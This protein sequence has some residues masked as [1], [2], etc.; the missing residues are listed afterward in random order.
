MPVYEIINPSDKCT[1]EAPGDAVA[2]VAVLLLGQGAFGVERCDGDTMRPILPFFRF[3]SN[4]EVA[5]EAW[6]RDELGTPL[7]DNISAHKSLLAAALESVLYGSAEDRRVYHRALD[8]IDDPT[9]RQQWRD[10]W[11]DSRRSSMNKICG[12]AWSMARAMASEGAI[13]NA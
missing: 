2:A 7:D 9:K 5:L 1:L 12:A 3:A 10:E 8:L 4:A 6:A 13:T 11:E